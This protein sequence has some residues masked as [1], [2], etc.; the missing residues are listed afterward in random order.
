MQDGNEVACAAQVDGAP[1]GPSMNGRFPLD[2]GRAKA[3]ARL[4]PFLPGIADI[5]SAREDAGLARGKKQ[6]LALIH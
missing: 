3:E 6:C 5:G 4:S 1:D 2:N